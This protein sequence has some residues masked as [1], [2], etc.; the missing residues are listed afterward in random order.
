MKYNFKEEQITSPIDNSGNCFR[1]FTEPVSD[2]HYLCMTTGYMST[3]G[4]KV[5]STA[6]DA[7]LDKSPE[8]VK[9]LQ[10][11]DEERDIVWIPTILNIPDNGM[12]YPEGSIGNW[13]WRYASVVQI[14]EE[15][16]KN[17]PVPNKEGEYFTSKLDVENSQQF[18]DNEFYEACTAMGLITKDHQGSLVNA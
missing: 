18:A 3:S 11:Y 12:I 5:G 7:E 13:N 17:Y 15:E 1:V 9:A 8:L 10:K 4:F 6:L 2:D 14:P 16:Q